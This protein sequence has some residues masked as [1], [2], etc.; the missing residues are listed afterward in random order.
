MYKFLLY[1]IFLLG[2]DNNSSLT[3]NDSNFTSLTKEP[4]TQDIPLTLEEII[5]EKIENKY[6][7]ATLV[8]ITPTKNPDFTFVLTQ[9][10]MD[11]YALYLYDISDESNPLWK[12]T[13]EETNGNNYIHEVFPLEEDRVI[14]ITQHSNPWGNGSLV[15]FDY[16]KK[17][18]IALLPLTGTEAFSIM[19]AEDEKSITINTTTI[20]ISNPLN[21]RIL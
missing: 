20:D 1:A 12:Y 10:P 13:I 19:I 17:Q 2:C 15:T 18:N 21:P 7:N 14:Y 3:R 6:D 16:T 11:N 5:K 8:S 4:I 9:K